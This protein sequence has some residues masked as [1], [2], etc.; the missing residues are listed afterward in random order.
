MNDFN[1]RHSEVCVEL[2]EDVDHVYHDGARRPPRR[3]RR[4][5]ASSVSE[6]APY[7]DADGLM[8]SESRQRLKYLSA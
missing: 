7:L 4:Q 1:R 2:C 3:L 8:D 6:H 5:T